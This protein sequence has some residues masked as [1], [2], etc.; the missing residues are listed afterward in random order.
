M[1]LQVSQ[2]HGVV[3]ADRYAKAILLIV[4]VGAL[5]TPDSAFAQKKDWKNW[6]DC[7]TY[8]QQTRCTRENSMSNSSTFCLDHI[9]TPECNAYH[10]PK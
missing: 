10:Y 7:M 3:M 5:M 1:I 6:Q 2:L 4:T 9:C 8:C